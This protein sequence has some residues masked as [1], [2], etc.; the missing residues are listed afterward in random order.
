MRVT[1]YCP[2]CLTRRRTEPPEAVITCRRCGRDWPV[3]W[4]SSEGPIER[5]V[6]CGTA[7]FYVE[8]DFPA[9]IGCLVMVGCAASFLWTENLWILIGSAL[10]GT[11][12]WVVLPKR[13]I[14]YKCLAEYRG[15]PRHPA[16]QEYELTR[17][18]RYAEHRK[19]R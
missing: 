17:A 19:N 16:H 2:E 1:L 4:P 6:L 13:T 11:L 12:L 9:R 7:D 14:C 15:L 3:S 10:V 5:C 18:A 8:S